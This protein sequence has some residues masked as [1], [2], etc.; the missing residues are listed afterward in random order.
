MSRNFL[1]TPR[2]GVV[3]RA[4]GCA[5]NAISAMTEIGS[6]GI[7]LQQSGWIAHI[8]RGYDRLK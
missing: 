4:Y 3:M 8:L 7:F 1:I 5:V 6:A 2:R